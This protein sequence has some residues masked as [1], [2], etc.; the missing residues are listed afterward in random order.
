MAILS[1]SCRARVVIGQSAFIDFD[2]PVLFSS[3]DRLIVFVC[4]LMPLMHD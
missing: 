4:L 3:C 1:Q 2:D